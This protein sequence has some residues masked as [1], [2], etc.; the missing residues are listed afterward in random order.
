MVAY[1]SILPPN[2]LGDLISPIADLSETEFSA[3][4]AAVST[5]RSFSLKKEEIERLRNELPQAAAR[6]LTF[7]LTALSFLYGHLLRLTEAGM[8]YD[9]AVK[10]T[11]EELESDAKWGSKKT[12]ATDRLALLF[13]QDVH[14]QLRKIQR[15]Q[16]GFLPNALGFATFID[17]RP[18]FGD[19]LNS[20]QLRAYV[21]IIQFR[22]TTDSQSPEQ[23]SIVFQMSESALSDLRKAITHAETKLD[24]LKEK[25]KIGPE[26]LRDD[27]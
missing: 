3:L 10:A 6:N 23:K 5:K 27:Q 4:N 12:I 11:A 24:I 2:S 14:Q 9:E 21:P 7:L 25:S 18:D 20:P 1:S 19:N 17:V 22:I 13:K 26:I 8:Q 16:S 15:L